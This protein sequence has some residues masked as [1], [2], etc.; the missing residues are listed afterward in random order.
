MNYITL[1]PRE[2]VDLAIFIIKN[3]GMSIRVEQSS[4]SGIGVNTLVQSTERKDDL[5]AYV[6]EQKDITDV[7]SW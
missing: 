2:A 1:T 5:K 7:E 3:E 4:S 6:V